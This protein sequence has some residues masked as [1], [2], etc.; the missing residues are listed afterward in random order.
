MQKRI[1]FTLFVSVIIYA[2]QG[3]VSKGFDYAPYFSAII[4]KNMDTSIRWYE[5]VFSLTVKQKGDFPQT[6]LATLASSGF[7]L[8]LLE[9][10]SSINPAEILQGKPAGTHMKGLFKIGFKVA[11]IDACLKHLAGLQIK[12]PF[13]HTDATTKKR[14]FIITDPDGNLIQFF[15]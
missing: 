10:K 9:I 4:V 13:V 6:R 8:E 14:N 5:S 15:D 1:F 11:D 7:E 12:K 2:S 3:Q